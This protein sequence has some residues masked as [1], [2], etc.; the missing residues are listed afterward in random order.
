MRTFYHTKAFYSAAALAVCLLTQPA[1]AKVL[2]AACFTDNMVLQQKAKANVWGTAKPGSKLTIIPTWDKKAYQVNVAANG[3]WTAKIATPSYGGPYQIAFDDGEKL[4]LNN[5]LIGDIW[6]C[7]GQSNMEMTVGNG[8]GGV[9]NAMQEIA[10]AT[11]YGDIRMIK[12]DNKTNFQ[13]QQEVPVKWGWR[14][15]NPENVKEFSAVAYFFARKI[16]QEKHIP[17]GL[18]SDNW[19]GT[20]AEAWTSGTSLKTMPEFADFVKAAEGGLTQNDIE[21][22]YKTEVR[23]WID[24]SRTDDPGYKGTTATWAQPDF[25]D[26]NWPKMQLP[27]F[28]EQAGLN[29][30]DGSVWF[31]KEINVPAEWAGKDLKLNLMGVD[32]YDVS[33]F[34]GQEVGH[35]E[36][37]FYPRNYT[38]PVNLVK[39]GKNIIAVRVFDNGG[40]GGIN[41]GPLTLQL[42]NDPA[43]TLDLAGEW[44]YQKALPLARLEQ[45][46]VLA[47]SANRPTLIYNAMIN[48]ILDFNIKGVIWYQGESNADRAE[49]YKTLFPLLIND[50]RNKFKNPNLPFYFVQI[51]NYDCHDQPVAADWPELR[52]AQLQTL[53]LPNTGMAVT[54]DIGE[55]TNIH[56]RNKQDVGSR[57]ALIALAKNY[58][59]KVPYSGPSY[60]SLQTKDNRVVL[61]FTNTSGGLTSKGSAALKGFFIAGADKKFYSAD[62]TINGNTVTVSNSLVKQP[63]AVRYDWQNNPDGTLYNGAGLPA[64]PFKTDDWQNIKLDPQK[65]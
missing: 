12:I 56:P 57:L 51:A 21:N 40:L 38:V 6:L 16:Y 59:V 13:P 44:T 26:S 18:I 54:I 8:F 1:L 20:V 47:N 3:K 17:I 15:C 60:S 34:N 58:G 7:S 65:Q 52:F 41:K 42:A 37:F 49:Q 25:N 46:P 33:F 10:D 11:K 29:N 53:K 62:A 64:S 9:L 45:P 48:P 14:V 4:T 32:D 36:M 63:V 61:S 27:N 55:A 50:W 43:K 22:R 23:H 24:R 39:A 30:Y 35:T 2:P 31:R 28:W 19:G 5:V